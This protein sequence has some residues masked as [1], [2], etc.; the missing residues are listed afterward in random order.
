MCHDFS[1]TVYTYSVT[2][3]AVLNIADAT[4]GCRLPLFSWT[5]LMRRW[6]LP[7]WTSSHLTARR[8]GYFPQAPRRC[9]MYLLKYFDSSPL[10]WL[11][12]S[13]IRMT[14]LVVVFETLHFMLTVFNFYFI[15]LN[16]LVNHHL[17]ISLDIRV[18]RFLCE[19]R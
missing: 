8:Q 7:F 14:R 2:P 12:V 10:G 5:S 6:P 15:F 13:I 3:I 4:G 18:M 1:L 19:L 9:I 11:L 16:I 17:L